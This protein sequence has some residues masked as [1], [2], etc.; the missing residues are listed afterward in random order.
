[1]NLRC[2]K[3]KNTTPSLFSVLSMQLVSLYK[4]LEVW[5]WAINF[6]FTH[7]IICTLNSNIISF[8][9]STSFW[10]LLILRWQIRR[11]SFIACSVVQHVMGQ[12]QLSGL[13]ESFHLLCEHPQPQNN[14]SRQKT[15][16]SQKGILNNRVSRP[17]FD[18]QT[19]V[20]VCS[21]YNS[22]SY[23]WHDTDLCT[24]KI[25]LHDDWQQLALS[26]LYISR[27][28]GF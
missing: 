28:L 15:A 22:C 26:S 7:A 20:N 25:L 24:S 8:S 14:L 13:T 11:S 2:E 19:A 23:I 4:A 16:T 12:R 5:V 3:H 27:V 1:M 10:M 6:A 18:S 17:I 21:Q 9:S